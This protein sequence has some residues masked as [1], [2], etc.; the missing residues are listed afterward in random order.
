M[1]GLSAALEAAQ[2][3]A[4]IAILEM[5][6]VFEGTSFISGGKV[7]IVGTALHKR[8]GIDELPDLAVGDFIEWSRDLDREWVRFYADHSNEEIY[9]WLAESVVR[10]RSDSKGLLRSA[11]ANRGPLTCPSP[12]QGMPHC[13]EN[14]SCA[15]FNAPPISP[16]PED[17]LAAIA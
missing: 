1:T 8:Q 9:E 5:W 7:A 12:L 14:T 16:I 11:A 13:S 17:S 6:S 2:D 4:R 10:F 3:G 15:S